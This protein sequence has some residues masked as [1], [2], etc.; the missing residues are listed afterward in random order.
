[1][2]AVADM[3]AGL[4]CARQIISASAILALIS[5]SATAH[6]TACTSPDPEPN[7]DPNPNCIYKPRRTRA[8]ITI[9]AGILVLRAKECASPA[10][11]V[12]I[13]SL[14]TGRL[15]SGRDRTRDLL[16]RK[17]A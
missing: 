12:P 13:L 9:A 14:V 4:L 17:Q 7:P 3:C 10:E 15:A 2:Q 6:M 1:M 11:A 16:R 8:L 5:A